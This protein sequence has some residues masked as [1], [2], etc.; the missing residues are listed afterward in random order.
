MSN[1]VSSEL[2]TCPNEGTHYRKES[3]KVV[4]N[5]IYQC[6]CGCKFEWYDS[7]SCFIINEGYRGANHTIPARVQ[8]KKENSPLGTF[9][10]IYALTAMIMFGVGMVLL[11]VSR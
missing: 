5:S 6:S 3:I 9:F 10:V 7:D 4:G 11:V 1:Y 2:A 8:N